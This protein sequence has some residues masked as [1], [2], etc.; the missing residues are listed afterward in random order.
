MSSKALFYQRSLYK[1]KIYP[2]TFPPPLDVWYNKLLYGR[3]DQFQN[4]I[5]P[6]T[7]NLKSIP[8]SAGVRVSALNVAVVAFEKF[9]RHMA[10][11]NTVGAVVRT[12]N[13]RLLEMKAY[14]GFDSPDSR[15]ATFAQ[16][17]CN[18]FVRS[19]KGKIASEIKDFPTFL[20]AYRNYLLTVATMT[21]IT[22]TNYLLS[23]KT[24][25]FTSGIS[26]SISGDDASD[27][28]EKYEKFIS[29]P[30]FEFYRRCAKKYGFTVNK[31]MPWVLTADL[32][33]SAFMDTGLKNIMLSDGTAITKDTFF[34][35]FYNK[36]HLTDF[37]DLINILVNSYLKL[38]KMSPRYEDDAF[39]IRGMALPDTPIELINSTCP[40]KT[41]PRA[42]LG[43]TAQQ[44]IDG[45]A[46]ADTLPTRMLIDLY[47]DL[48]QTEVNAPLAP[49]KLKSVKMTAYEVYSVR[50]N[51]TLSPLQNVAD[52]VNTVFRDYIYDYGAMD[53]QFKN[54]VNFAL[55]NRTLGD[56]IL[57]ENASLRQLY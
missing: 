12:G 56:T 16:S 26:I 35:T 44:V 49:P 42:P 47:V 20:K 22:K 19:L 15:Y 3:I 21:P 2:S 29:D 37:N 41:V 43:A 31:D 33:S 51:Q 23:S 5:L 57:V 17:L 6:G 39:G 40:I 55:D 53:L 50:P 1:E 14:K 38:L 13:P 4:S 27:D 10:K 8:S 7:E 24:S 9:V 32:F 28:R 45:T 54:G 30:N 18:A 36:T 46:P 11:A 52:Y 34:S 48:R 25:I